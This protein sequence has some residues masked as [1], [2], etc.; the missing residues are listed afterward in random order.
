MSYA[1]MI[2]EWQALGFKVRLIFLRL[3]LADTAIER[4]ALRVAHGGHNI[5]DEDIRRRF[6]RGLENFESVFKPLVDSWALYA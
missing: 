3:D 6:V 1:R 5:P 2:P 4:V